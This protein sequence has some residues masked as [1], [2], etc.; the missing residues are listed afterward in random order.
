MRHIFTITAAILFLSLKCFGNNNIKEY[1]LNINRAEMYIVGQKLDSALQFY[2]IAF[3]KQRPFAIDLYNALVCA[4]ETKQF[5]LALDLSNELAKKG[6]GRF[7]FEQKTVFKPLIKTTEWQLILKR[8]GY[9]KDSLSTANA[10]LLKSLEQLTEADYNW[11]QIR[12]MWSTEE[13]LINHSVSK[14]FNDSTSKVMLSLM[15]QY[16]FLGEDILGAAMAN[17]TT[18]N[19]EYPFSVVI[20]HAFQNSSWH[21]R[22][23]F[24]EKILN[25]LNEGRISPNSIIRYTDMS[26]VF[27]YSTGTL[28]SFAM[29]GCQLWRQEFSQDAINRFNDFREGHYIAPLEDYQAKACYLFINSNT[30][31]I[32]PKHYIIM[33]KA[34]NI[35]SIDNYMSGYK[36]VI[37]KVNNCN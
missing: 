33:N 5:K 4:I 18:L 12:H 21:N 32:M 30:N 6:V 35:T 17:D 29:F 26:P 20:L 27:G 1:S 3:Q 10:K 28:S 15:E 11:G 22:I 19:F 2:Q 9:V 13:Y 24:R 16:G 23:V 37:E 25:A 14:Q 31:W 36:L 34:D 7:F 8:A